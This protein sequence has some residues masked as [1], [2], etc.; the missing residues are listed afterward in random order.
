MNTVLL[1]TYRKDTMY[2]NPVSIQTS[3]LT[4]HLY[5]PQKRSLSIQIPD[6]TSNL[7]SPIPDPQSIQNSDPDLQSMFS[8]TRPPP[9]PHPQSIQN[10]DQTPN[11]TRDLIFTVYRQA[12]PNILGPVPGLKITAGIRWGIA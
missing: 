1:N 11:P 4:P 6:Q 3:D 7:Y 10:S 8:H 5:N 2:T 12:Q 9:P